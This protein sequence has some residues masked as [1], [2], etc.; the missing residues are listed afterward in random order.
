V[1]R[2]STA[3]PL[4]RVSLR[5]VKDFAKPLEVTHPGGKE[6][7]WKWHLL[8]QEEAERRIRGQ[9]GVSPPPPAPVPAQP[10]AA[11][12]A[13]PA[14][15]AQPAV[16]GP[17]PVSKPAGPEQQTLVQAPVQPRPRPRRASR[18]RKPLEPSAD[19]AY[20]HVMEFFGKSGMRVLEHRMHRTG[21][22]DFVV[23]MET[24]LGRSTC[25][26][27]AISKARL[28][29]A[30][31][32]DAYAEGMLRRLPTVVLTAGQLT[33]AAE[34]RLPALKGLGIKRI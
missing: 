22:H 8:P 17:A 7:F 12:A 11:P 27:R 20:R 6:L 34:A 5:T 30:D 21:L 29:D 15:A 18:P 2:D 13:A 14:P 10:P 24:P 23:E 3:D 16:P 1:L 9:L 33:K 19:A 25:H 4:T 31:L 28:T 26:C 32:G